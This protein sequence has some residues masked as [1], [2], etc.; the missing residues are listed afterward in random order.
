MSVSP[1]AAYPGLLLGDRYE[2]G[3]PLASGG[4]AQVWRGR[5]I[6]L[7]RIVAIKVLHPHLAGDDA[8]VT[9]FRREAVAA[10][11]LSHR[12][13]VGVYDTVSDRGFE[14]IVMELIDGETLRDQLNRLTVMPPT[15]VVRIGIQ[16]AGALDDAHRA[17]IVHRDIK[18]AN[19]MMCIDGRV[20]VTDFGIAKA[21]K[22]DDL[23]HTGTLLGTAKYLAPEQV[24]GEPIDPRADLYALGI[25]LFEAATGSVPF[26]AGTDAATALA[27]LQHDA[28][29][30]RHRRP[31][32]PVQLDAVI[33][34]ATARNPDHR[35]DRAT[36][37][38]DALSQVDVSVVRLDTSDLPP[39]ATTG[40]G[41]PTLNNPVVPDDATSNTAPGTTPPAAT[42]PAPPAGP[43]TGPPPPAPAS[44]G[45]GSGPAVSPSG[46][47]VLPAGGLP[48]SVGPPSGSVPTV[49]PSAKPKGR[50]RL[51]RRIVVATLAI[52]ALIAA[53][54][55]LGGTGSGEPAVMI[56][57][58]PFDP[59]GTPPYR[60]RHDLA[61][62]AI[63]GDPDSAWQT[64]SY[65]RAQFGGGLKSGVGL[66]LELEQRAAINE[67]TLATDSSGWSVEI[68]LS[69]EG[70]FG[71]NGDDFEP[72]DFEFVGE[73]SGDNTVSQS[74]L[75]G[76]GRFVL[77]WITETGK[78]NNG[79]ER[80]R[81]V[82]NEV[83]VR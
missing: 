8:F 40:I 17:G 33:A 35:Y 80:H 5:D 19:I 79:D 9:R 28:P 13:I 59:E 39:P 3:T 23:T 53:V 75:D 21:N 83:T 7:D 57:A 22:D 38:R 70:D 63:D 61:P 18:P 69:D 31:D 20:L 12:S 50:G 49:P 2:L 4:M 74:G 78:P 46:T 58:T 24:A 11:R 76:T 72:D 47:Q 48:P 67:V 42:T 68:Y 45:P 1:A 29:R 64:E 30:A 81:F 6:T 44:P 55:T 37:M 60:E 51:L 25:V 66:I 77:L 36:S 26:N 34:K 82:L 56:Q 16:V 52:V 32:V 71:D 73:L 14:A 65:T 27:R 10:A 54:N 41:A 43:P 62:N 15:E